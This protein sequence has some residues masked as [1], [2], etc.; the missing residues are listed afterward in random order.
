MSD[1]KDTIIRRPY[2]TVEKDGDFEKIV[3]EDYK[4]QEEYYPHDDVCFVAFSDG[5][6]IRYDKDGD[7]KL[8]VVEKGSGYLVDKRN[9][10]EYSNC[11][12]FKEDSISWAVFGDLH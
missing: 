8:L 12:G 7:E 5:T 6:L 4:F 11:C 2:V 1:K 10:K 9:K 3:V